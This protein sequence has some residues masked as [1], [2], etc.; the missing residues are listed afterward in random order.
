MRLEASPMTV[1]EFEDALE[2][3][4]RG[5]IMTDLGANEQLNEIL[6]TIVFEGWTAEREAQA[7]AAF[8]SLVTD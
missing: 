6:D 2:Q 8:R 4:S 3:A 1:E 5:V 7:R